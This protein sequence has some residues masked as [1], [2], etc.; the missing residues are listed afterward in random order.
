MKTPMSTGEVARLLG[1]TE[2][3][4]SELVRRG[5]IKPPPALLAGRRFWSREDIVRAARHLG[6]LERLKER[7]PS[8]VPNAS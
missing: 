5:K 8:E 7:S 1:L 6:L 2:P 3:R 4:L